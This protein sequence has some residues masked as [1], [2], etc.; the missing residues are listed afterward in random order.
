MRSTRLPCSGSARSAL[1]VRVGSSTSAMTASK[2]ACFVGK[3]RKIVPSAI[4]AA[5]ATCFVVNP[6]P[7]AT[8]SGR[9]A[10]MIARRRSSGA[11]VLLCSRTAR[12]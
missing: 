3:T 12:V 5:S 8:R 9:A 6:P 10:A 2:R 7:L 4:P 11:W 1:V